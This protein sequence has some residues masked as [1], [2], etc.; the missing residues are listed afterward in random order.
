[1]VV[2]G[3]FDD[4]EDPTTG[5]QQCY[6]YQSANQDGVAPFSPLARRWR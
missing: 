2:R 1:M 6:R 3:K 5:D 4:R